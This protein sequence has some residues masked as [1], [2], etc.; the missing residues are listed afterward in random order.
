MKRNLALAFS[1]LLLGGCFEQEQASAPTP[2]TMTA[3]ALG[4]YCQMTLIEHPGPKGQIH[5]AG[6][7]QPI[8][9]SQVRDAIAYQRMPEQ[10]GEIAAI[11]VSDMGA[12][13]S[14]EEPGADNWISASEA[15]FVAGSHARGGMGAPELVPFSERSAAEAFAEQRGGRVLILSEVADEEVL[16]PAAPVAA[17]E[18]E[19]RYHER[20][21]SLSHGKGS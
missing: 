2:V 9:F 1:F 6:Q 7:Q 4:F 19:H 5:L 21:E 11:Y 15:Y 18:E 8:F 14:W 10:S 3:D 17:G 16:G 13:T 20:L 12:A